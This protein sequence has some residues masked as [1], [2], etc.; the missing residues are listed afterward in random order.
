MPKQKVTKK[1]EENMKIARIIEA[2]RPREK[3]QGQVRVAPV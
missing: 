3:P 2:L 1:K